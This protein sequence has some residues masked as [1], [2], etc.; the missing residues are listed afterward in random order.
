MTTRRFSGVENFAVLVSLASVAIS[1]IG[2]RTRER[3][4]GAS[5]RPY[6]ALSASNAI[7]DGAKRVLAFSLTNA[8][9]GPARIRNFSLERGRRNVSSAGELL[10]QCCGLDEVSLVTSTVVGRALRPGDSATYL[11]LP[12]SDAIADGRKALDKAHF[13]RMGM[14][15]C[16]CSTPDDCF[17][18][19]PDRDDAQPVAARGVAPRDAQYR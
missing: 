12:Y 4:L 16:Y 1:V 5:A 11:Q 9:S 15:V 2:N 14:T 13:D 17:E 18:A 6:V 7:D 8:V 19:R 10:R 3:L